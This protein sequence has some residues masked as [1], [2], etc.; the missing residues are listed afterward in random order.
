MG[1]VEYAPGEPKG[2]PWH[3]HRGFETVTYMHR[4]RVPPPGLQ[5]RRRPDHQRRHPVDDRGRRHPAHRGAARGAGDERRPVPRLPAL[6]QPARTAQDD[7]AALPGHPRRPGRA[8]HLAGRRRAAAGHRRRGRRPRRARAS[9]TPRSPWC[10]PR[11]RRA[12]RSACRGA[13]TSTRSATCSRAPARS[14]PDRRPIHTGQLAVFGFGESITFARR[15][16]R[17]TARARPSTSCCSAASRSASRS[18]PT[19]R[20]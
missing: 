3:P 4:R 6:G 20:S 19:A 18:P 8:A 10:T 17:W 16:R 13:R 5:R 7:P 1:E 14:A 12:R 9:R 15:P 11:S 2:T